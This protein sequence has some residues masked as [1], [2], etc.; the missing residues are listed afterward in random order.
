MLSDLRYRL[1]AL[2]RRSRVERELDDELRFH[3]ERQR[4][5]YIASGMPA[6]DAARRVR[7]DFGTTDA[8]KEECRDA[9]GI[10]AFEEIIR[11][12]RYARRTLAR[13]P[14]F[15]TVVVVT[16]GLG[17]GANSAVFSALHAVV[18]R[19]LPFPEA[20]QL[21][22]IE[23]Y[24]PGAAQAS[25][26]A[27][28]ARVE[29]WHR[30][31]GTFQA[32]SGY[33]G[34]DL[35]ETS[36]ELP[37]RI[38][39]AWVAPRF[40]E[41][42]GVA[43]AFGRIFTRDEERFGGPAVAIVSERF[44]KRRFGENNTLRERSL[45]IGGRSVTIV[46]VM[47][48]PFAFPN[49][50]VD[51]WRP[52]PPDSPYARNR[53]ATWFRTI[54]RLRTGV[55]ADQAVSDLNRVQAGLGQQYPETDAKLAVR[56]TA[57]KAATLG[58]ISKSLWMLFAAVSL[59]LLIACTNIAALLLARN[60]ERRRE[61]S[62]RFSLGASRSAVVRQLLTEALVLACLGS[63][64]GIAIAVA[65]FQ[66][67]RSLG[68]GL[69][70]M[71]EIRLDW[72]VILYSLTC[73]VGASIIFGLFPALRTARAVADANSHRR[74]ETIATNRLQWMLVG[75]QVALSVTLLFGAGLLI[76]SFDRLARVPPGFDASRVM[77][78]RITGNWGE[79]TDMAGLRRRMLTALD[80]L[81]STPGVA[82]AATSVA[83]PACRFVT[84]RS[85]E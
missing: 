65:A 57:L 14:G 31:T 85:C 22:T 11:N 43:P 54:G 21:V 10:H 49:A 62:I 27:A 17:I 59:L 1:R 56:V 15:A 12:V 82:A 32:I 42:C 35:T 36:G 44:W 53:A 72:A 3:L 71:M 6:R 61:I 63:A 30:L 13:R 70:R 19:S 73:A 18:L 67:F 47:P 41:V 69:P 5:K 60:A 79:T 45:R 37:E 46:G 51:V 84:T 2:F 55:S 68:A 24:E 81:R 48:P 23:Q 25:I 16:L 76:R 64:V 33:F 26:F 77:T 74:T 28:P 39:E 9:R 8:I 52:S 38:S 83:V 66:A 75:I 80:A 7:I 50:D 4:D 29:D 34:D 78:F 20:D 40:F 58:S